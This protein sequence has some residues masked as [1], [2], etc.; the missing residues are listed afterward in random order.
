M[1]GIWGKPKGI[2]ALWWGGI[3]RPKGCIPMPPM[4]PMP[5][6]SPPNGSPPKNEFTTEFICLKIGPNEIISLFYTNFPSVSLSH[7]NCVTFK[8]SHFWGF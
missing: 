3:I 5:P 8:K 4:P 6:R 2:S 1:V 7:T